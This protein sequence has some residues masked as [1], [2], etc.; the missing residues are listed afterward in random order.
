VDYGFV[1]K[2]IAEIASDY[3]VVGLA[4]DRWRIEGLLRELTGIGVDAFVGGK[5]HPRAGALR[6]I[7]WGQGWRDMA[8]AIDALEI[9]VLERRFR[10]PGNP[11]LTF[12]FANAVAIADPS[13]NR[14]LDKSATRFRIDGAVATATVIGCK[15]SKPTEQPAGGSYLE[16]KPL[17]FV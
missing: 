10:H 15:A 16:T 1:A 2:R 12:C 3:E 9:A 5:E 7:P 11:V 8:P 13:G 17:L 14:K 6:L 4:Y